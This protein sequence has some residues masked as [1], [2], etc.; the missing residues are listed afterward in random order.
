MRY[1]MLASADFAAHWFRKGVNRESLR[2]TPAV[3]F[4][5]KDLMHSEILL[6]GY[7]LLMQSYPYSF[8]PATDAFVKAIQLGLGYGMVPE[9]QVQ[10][11][12]ENGT[13]VDIMP[14]AQLDIPL[15]WHHWKRQS[16]QLNVLTECIVQAAKQALK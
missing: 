9:L 12:L 1:K 13:L 7:G 3:I 6:K 10:P 16:E 15:Y 8:I 14:D 5:H 2:K 4:N 11:L